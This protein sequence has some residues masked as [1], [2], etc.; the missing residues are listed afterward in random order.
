[1]LKIKGLYVKLMSLVSIVNCRKCGGG[2]FYSS[3]K[4]SE[5]CSY[6][7]ETTDD[8][9]YFEEMIEEQDQKIKMLEQRIEILEQAIKT[10]VEK[11]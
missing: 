11:S 9:R 8:K 7:C 3:S 10:I 5:Y 1:M 4:P 6:T 2:Y